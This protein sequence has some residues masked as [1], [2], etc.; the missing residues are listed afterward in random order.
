MELTESW[1][2]V[3][4]QDIQDRYT[5][6]ETRNAAA[7]MQATNPDEF[8][9][10]CRVLSDF[11]LTTEMILTKGGNKTPAALTLDTAFREGGWRE[12]KYEQTIDTRLIINPYRAGGERAKRQRHAHNVNEG[13]QV[14]NVKGRIALDVEWNA[15][16]GNLDRD[17]SNFRALYEAGQIDVAVMVTRITGK[18]RALAADLIRLAKAQAEQD[19][20]YERLG[21]LRKLADDPLGS[22]TTTNLEKLTPRI[23]RGDAGGCPLLAIAIT[24]RCFVPPDNVATAVA[25]AASTVGSAN[26]TVDNPEDDE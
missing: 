16:D 2:D 15:K 22:T 19:G 18:L 21:V 24:E 23:G 13:H 5:I 10:M 14:D 25:E 6:V 7:I 8:D 12:A 3:L 20:D 9:V 17:I 26:Q 4:P 1:K 11:Q